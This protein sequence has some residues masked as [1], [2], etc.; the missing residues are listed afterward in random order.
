MIVMSKEERFFLPRSKSDKL[1]LALIVAPSG[2]YLI[3]MVFR[4]ILSYDGR[5]HGVLESG[6]ECTLLEFIFSELTSTFFLPFMVLITLFWM[7]TIGVIYF[8][9]R[10]FKRISKG[11]ET[12]T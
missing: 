5:Y 6:S 3:Y 2:I 8:A 9:V 1:W 4:F 11:K 7:G 10:I 12:Q